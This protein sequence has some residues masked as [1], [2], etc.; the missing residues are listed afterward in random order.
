MPFPEDLNIFTV[1]E[2]IILNKLVVENTKEYV[3]NHLTLAE[4]V[5]LDDEMI[6]TLQ[7]LRSKIE[8]ISDDEWNEMKAYF[9]CE[10]PYSERDFDF[11]MNEDN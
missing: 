1:D 9:P 5:S 10:V 6:S 2:K 3:L 8:K 11:V 4:E 7:E